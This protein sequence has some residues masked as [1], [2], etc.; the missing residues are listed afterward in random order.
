MSE[1]DADSSISR[2]LT[3]LYDITEGFVYIATKDPTTAD[4]EQHFFHW[5]QDRQRAEEFIIANG[6]RTNVYIA[7]ALFKSTETA[8]KR[9]VLGS[10][11]YWAEFDGKVPTPETLALHRIPEPTMR[12]RSSEEG[13]EHWYW[14]C[15]EF[16]TDVPNIDAVNRGITYSLGADPSGWD[17]DQVL[18][19][20]ATTNFKRNRRVEFIL[21]SD[22]IVNKHDLE[23]ISAEHS[24]ASTDEYQEDDVEPLQ[25]LIGRYDFTRYELD[26][27]APTQEGDRSDRIY[28]IAMFCAEKN[29]T[30]KE[31][32]SVIYWADK[33]VGKF[34]DRSDKIRQYNNIV[35]RARAKYPLEEISSG[36][37]LRTATDIVNDPVEIEWQIQG[38][39]QR[40]GLMVLAGEPGVG[41]S[42]LS[43]QFLMAMAMEQS[44]YLSFPI[45]AG[46]KGLFISLEMP[47]VEL[48]SL[49]QTMLVD[50]SVEDRKKL[51]ENLYWIDRGENLNFRNQNV[52]ALIEQIIADNHLELVVID[53]FSKMGIR[54]MQDEEQILEMMGWFDHVRSKYNCSIWI[55]HHNRKSNSDRKAD[56][57]D[58]VYGSRFITAGATSVV[59]M[60][61]AKGR[62]TIKLKFEKIRTAPEKMPLLI[63]RR[64]H[65]LSF[66]TSGIAALAETVEESLSDEADISFEEPV[67][68]GPEVDDNDINMDF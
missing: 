36:L 19:P 32:F 38:L 31:I 48:K 21:S 64:I 12:V 20:P 42:Q 52:R 55:I 35:S 8:K 61:R 40:S 7:P 39:L 37:V 67:G 5:P 44:D 6:S 9:N 51:D 3:T 68:M 10:H 2:Y 15:S 1:V 47:T 13:R 11:V 43:M 66:S 23:Q 33:K 26:R 46:R 50:I 49:F 28:E 34:T 16:N 30:D 14:R 65:N 18:R 4:W 41:K 63:Q 59:V 27:M 54:K 17:A 22:T 53:S 29:M 58:D 56:S 62:N 25:Y 57:M 24:I 60:S 45:L